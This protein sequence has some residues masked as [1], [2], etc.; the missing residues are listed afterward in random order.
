MRAFNY[1]IP[2]ALL[3]SLAACGGGGGGSPGSS[4][5][6]PT[7]SAG[8]DQAVDEQTNVSLSG[9][10]SQDPDG[11]IAGYLWSQL[12]GTTV[13][14]QNSVAETASFTAPALSVSEILSFQLRVTDNG[15]VSAVDTIQVTVNPV[16][17]LNAPPVADAGADQTLAELVLATP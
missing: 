10:G 7:A 8:T 5:S 4:N 16:A 3:G 9:A 12:S 1:L 17:G 14:L 6:A 15:N 13:A 2:I 11:T